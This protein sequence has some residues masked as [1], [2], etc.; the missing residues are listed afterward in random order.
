MTKL[1]FIGEACDGV[2]CQVT[3][4]GKLLE[5]LKTTDVTL[6]VNACAEAAQWRYDHKMPHVEKYCKMEERLAKLSDVLDQKIDEQSKKLL[7]EARH[8]ARTKK[9]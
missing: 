3:L 5:T 9:S 8:V 4:L 1:D 2:K 7:A 6:L